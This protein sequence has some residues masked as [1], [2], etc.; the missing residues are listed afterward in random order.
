MSQQ[1]INKDIQD[2]ERKLNSLQVDYDFYNNGVMFVEAEPKSAN[3]LFGNGK[4]KKTIIDNLGEDVFKE[5]CEKYVNGNSTK[6]IDFKITCLKV[7]KYAKYFQPGQTIEVLDETGWYTKKYKCAG[8][9]V[10][11]IYIMAP[12]KGNATGKVINISQKNGY[13]NSIKKYQQ[14][15][16]DLA[17]NLRTIN[18]TT[19]NQIR[20]QETESTS[21]IQESMDENKKNENFWATNKDKNKKAIKT[22]ATVAGIILLLIAAYFI[23]NKY[24]S[25]K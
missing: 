1:L 13:M 12:F 9:Q 24:K 3:H 16:Q 2:I 18:N 6:A 7:G 10:D 25:K 15:I 5:N 23:Y 20:E 17:P 14:M 11:G 4:W 21:I 8:V 19:K 22:A